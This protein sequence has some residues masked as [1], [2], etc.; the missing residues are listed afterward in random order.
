[1]LGRSFRTLADAWTPQRHVLLG[2]E[3]VLNVFGAVG[4]S[5]GAVCAALSV[6]ASP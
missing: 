1:M 3:I 6:P 5:F 2:V 4:D